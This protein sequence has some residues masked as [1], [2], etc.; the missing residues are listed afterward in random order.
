MEKLAFT[1]PGQGRVADGAA[2]PWRDDPAGWP[3]VQASETLGWDVVAAL[4]QGDRALADTRTA[5]PA[6]FTHSVACYLLARAEGLRPDIVAGHS[7][8]EYAALVAA[9]GMSF[10]QGLELVCRRA[11]LAH[12]AGGRGAMRV[13]LGLP[14][15]A[16]RKICRSASSRSDHVY[17]ANSNAPGQVVIS[18][19]AVAVE[20]AARLALAAGAKRVLALPIGGSF[21]TP[22]MA[23]ARRPFREVLDHMQLPRLE[24][25]FVSNARARVVRSGQRAGRL[26]ARQLTAPVEWTRCVERLR[27]FGTTT[28]IELG[29][30][31]VLGNLIRRIDPRAEV[32]AVST[33]E[34]VRTLAQSVLTT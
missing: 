10:E 8:G 21:H 34:E 3:F 19:D 32:R 12:R 22:L 2:T 15:D 29:P 20:E 17:L 23:S 13:I 27:A 18:G 16:V 24:V 4:E 9:G 11:D 6:I 30:A 14:D 1:F 28:Y 26:L 33:P 7:L 25:P 5:Q 31:R